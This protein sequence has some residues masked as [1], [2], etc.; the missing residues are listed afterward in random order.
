MRTN[1]IE[2]GLVLLLG[3]IAVWDGSRILILKWGKMGVVGGGGYIIVLGLLLACLAV[4]HFLQGRS[5]AGGSAYNWGETQDLRR[6]G[7]AVFL[8]AGYVLAIQYLG[9]LLA[10]AVFFVVYLRVFS[11]YRW[12]MIVVSSFAGAVGAAYLW[13]YLGMTLP[14]GIL[15]WP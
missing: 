14:Q 8:A 9:Y 5:G 1:I 10:T 6:V 15:P 13:T 12:L 11:S 2:A 3:T 7:L 4:L